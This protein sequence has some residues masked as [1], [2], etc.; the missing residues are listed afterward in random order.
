M[1]ARMAVGGALLA[2]SLVWAAG[3]SSERGQRR[4]SETGNPGLDDPTPRDPA[5]PVTPPAAPPVTNPPRRDPPT[6]PAA[7]EPQPQPPDAGH[8]AGSAAA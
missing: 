3:C 2:A 6:T 8:A 7:A 1:K 5:D 4:W